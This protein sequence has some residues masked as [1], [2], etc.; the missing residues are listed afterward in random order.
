[1]RFTPAGPAHA[2]K[3]YSIKA[4]ISTHFRPA[5][6]AEVGCPNYTDGWRIRVEGLTPD[7]IYT[8]RNSGRKYTEL[9]IS[10]KEHWL[11]YEA[12]Q[13]C[14]QVSQHRTRVERPELYVVRDG[15]HRGNPRGTARRVHA[16]AEDWADDLHEHTDKILD[17]L[18]EG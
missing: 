6:C 16:N 11:V 17:A 4:P 14:F 18:K 1:V 8:A 9:E 12:G 13:P 5:T 10:E 3:T 2:Y 15:D 7:L